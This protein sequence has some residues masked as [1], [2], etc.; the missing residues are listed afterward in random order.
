MKRAMTKGST[1]NSMTIGEL[2]VTIEKLILD[3]EK[4]YQTIASNKS[5]SYVCDIKHLP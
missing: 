3:N 4:K 5:M 2:H 1:H